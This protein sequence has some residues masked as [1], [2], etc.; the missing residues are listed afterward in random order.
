MSKQ[1]PSRPK[2]KKWARR[3]KVTLIICF[4]G[5]WHKKCKLSW[6]DYDMICRAA[7]AAD[8]TFEEFMTKAIERFVGRC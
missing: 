5:G 1:R 7:D 6:N 4:E 3:R 8:E 2:S